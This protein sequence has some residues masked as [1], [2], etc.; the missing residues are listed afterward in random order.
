MNDAATAPGNANNIL[1]EELMIRAA[2]ASGASLPLLDSILNEFVA[3]IGPDLTQFLEAPVSAEF[4]R[5]IY[6]ACDEALEQIGE[7]GIFVKANVQ[8]FANP[9]VLWFDSLLLGRLVDALLGSTASEA[10]DG[11]RTFTRLEKHLIDQLAARLL[12][13]FASSYAGVRKIGIATA[14][15]KRPSSEDPDWIG[16]EKCVSIHAT[17]SEEETSGSVVVLLP[18][19]IFADDF[20]QLSVQPEAPTEPGIGSWQHEMSQALGR[21]GL[22][23]KAVLGDTSVPL[24]EALSWREGSVVRLETEA[25][26]DVRVI[27]GDHTVFQAVPGRRDNGVLALR[28]TSDVEM[29]RIEE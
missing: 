9:L 28:I 17:V 19:P 5:L 27:C 13:L 24:S 29:T 1:V 2:G 23:L 14:G 15:M 26:E 3:S 7:D 12:G 16:A 22:K 21:T 11:P 6:T 25:S 8:P 18:F 4:E 20:D 10:S